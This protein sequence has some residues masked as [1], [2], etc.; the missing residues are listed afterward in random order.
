M[1]LKRFR[2]RPLLGI[3]RGITPSELEPLFETIVASGLQSVEITMNT[4]G[5][6]GLIR[7]AVKRYGKSLMIGAGTVLN[8]K[9]AVAWS[10]SLCSTTI[11]ISASEAVA[12]SRSV[13]TV[14]IPMTPASASVKF[15]AAN[16][17]SN[18]KRRILLSPAPG[19]PEEKMDRYSYY[20][21]KK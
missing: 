20:K 5:A 21:K 16:G 6:A 12:E 17:A 19:I 1:D 7:S 15:A 9:A 3:L 2:Q 4:G 14:L 11:L 18:R 8:L 13:L 10:L